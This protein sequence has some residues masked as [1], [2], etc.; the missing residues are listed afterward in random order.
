MKGQ[1]GTLVGRSHELEAGKAL[2]DG[3]G[4]GRGGTCLIEGEAGIGKT[5]VL[6]E[7]VAEAE[8]R[9]ARP[10]GRRRRARARPALRARPPDR[11]PAGRR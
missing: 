2:L 10:S 8:P 1:H 11:S 6:G 7:L 9:A 4:R 3:L 5:R